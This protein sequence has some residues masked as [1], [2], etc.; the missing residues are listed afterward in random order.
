[1]LNII[2]FW[3]IDADDGGDNGDNDDEILLSWPRDLLL[4]WATP[5]ST[6]THMSGNKCDVDDDNN[7]DNDDDHDDDDE[8]DDDDDDDF[9]DVLKDG[10]QCILTQQSQNEPLIVAE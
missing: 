1:M 3:W 4:E 2:R 6:R 9:D 10:W 5:V 8:D 7:A